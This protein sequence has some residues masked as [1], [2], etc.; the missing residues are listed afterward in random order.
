[1]RTRFAIGVFCSIRY[2]G[3]HPALQGTPRML[4]LAYFAYMINFRVTRQELDAH[5]FEKK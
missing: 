1:M 4:N 5:N 3:E 2:L